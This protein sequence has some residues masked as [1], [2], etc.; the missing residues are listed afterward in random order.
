[1]NFRSFDNGFKQLYTNRHRTMQELCKS[2]VLTVD[3][4]VSKDPKLFLILTSVYTIAAYLVCVKIHCFLISSSKPL[5]WYTFEIETFYTCTMVTLKFGQKP[6][7]Y[8]ISRS[9][10]CMELNILTSLLCVREYDIQ[11]SKVFV[12]LLSIVN[13][14]LRVKQ[15]FISLYSYQKLP[16]SDQKLRVRPQVVGS[17]DC[18]IL[19]L[20]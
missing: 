13:V 9:I 12:K 3:R 2:N 14:Y 5:L 19:I 15:Q 10:F 11:G 6:A 8:M 18:N 16:R 4:V 20:F 7:I 1:M 17:I